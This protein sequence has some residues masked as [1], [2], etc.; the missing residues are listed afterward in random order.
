MGVQNCEYLLE[1]ILNREAFSDE[2]EALPM[3]TIVK[4]ESLNPS[5]E[6][7]RPVRRTSVG[8]RTGFSDLETG[9]SDLEAQLLQGVRNFSTGKCY[10]RC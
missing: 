4:V 7:R 10:Q 9:F 2:S 5:A 1:V 3:F 6:N 8:M